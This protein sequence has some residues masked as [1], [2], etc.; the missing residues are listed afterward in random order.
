V[1]QHYLS[2]FAEPLRLSHF[3]GTTEFSDFAAIFVPPLFADFDF[4]RG[5]RRRFTP[6]CLP[7]M[8]LT[9]SI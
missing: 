9:F 6:P 7:A 4:R 1:R 3:A 5:C 2:F 8:P